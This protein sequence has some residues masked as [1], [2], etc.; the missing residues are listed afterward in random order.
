MHIIIVGVGQLGYRLAE[1]LS[2]EYNSL[3]VVDVKPEALE[4]VN[5][6]LDVL[7]VLGNGVEVSVLKSMHI[8]KAD[9]MIAV[10]NRDEVNIL[11]CQIA[12]KLGCKRVIARI[13][14]PEYANQ[15]E[16]MKSS[17]RIDFI[18][19]PERE[20]ARD[21]AKYLLKG[22]AIHM[23]DFAQGKVGMADLRLQNYPGLVGQKIKT[24]D[25]LENLLLAA[26]VREGKIIVPYGDLELQSS[27]VVYII[28]K[29]ESINTF[30]KNNGANMERQSVTKALILGGGRAGY[31][32]ARKLL[33][34]GV[35]VKIVERDRERCNYL[36]SKLKRALVIHGDGTD[37]DLLNQE[38]HAEVDGMITLTGIDEENLLLALLGKQYGIRRVM[39]KVSRASYVPIIE[40]LGIDV[41]NPVLITAGE[42][43]RFIQ[44]GRVASL[45]LLF[46][47]QAEVVEII[48]DETARAVGI[49]LAHLGLPRGIIIGSIVHQGDVVIPRGSSVIQP[50]DRVIVFCVQSKVVM[51][52]KFFYPSKGG[53]F[54][55]LWDN[56]KGTRK[57]SSL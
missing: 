43:L 2:N 5:N 24:M 50:G 29:K 38:C 25:C 15:L 28:G 14:N 33:Q 22:N 27:D 42:I 17:M 40:Q 53:L 44:G 11:V 18:V 47:G 45:S 16:F 6:S 10:T 51:L 8:Q 19:N 4:R 57:P 48:V 56:Y 39:A 23:E 1:S 13:R 49:P 52:E 41:A 3:S 36:A 12:K 20:M 34:N 46:G 35:A 9:L 32:L 37:Q 7:T 55:E 30:T 54:R 26:I 31:H 21:I